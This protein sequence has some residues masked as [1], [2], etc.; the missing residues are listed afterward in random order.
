[1]CRA[2][3]N[4]LYLVFAALSGYPALVK[5]VPRGRAIAAYSKHSINNMD[6]I[7]SAIMAL[8]VKRTTP[9]RTFPPPKAAAAA[10][11]RRKHILEKVV[12]A[13]KAEKKKLAAAER[14]RLKAEEKKRLQR[15]AARQAR[16]K[17]AIL[18]LIVARDGVREFS[19]ALYRTAVEFRNKATD[20]WRTLISFIVDAAKA[21]GAMA[22]K[23][24]LAFFDFRQV[25]LGPCV[26][27]I[28]RP[29]NKRRPAGLDNFPAFVV[30]RCIRHCFLLVR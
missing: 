27:V 18:P 4:A 2:A 12:A 5:N 1:M 29:L 17:A 16:L 15:R 25:A 22:R 7:L 14:R 23:I 19:R 28:V 8:Q 3:D 21:V 24:T 11:G 9:K 20:A 6:A 30:V 10:R 13:E 26:L